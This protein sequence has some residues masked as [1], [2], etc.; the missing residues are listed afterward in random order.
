M[1]YGECL[2]LTS[3]VLWGAIPILVRKGFTALECIGGSGIRLVS[4][5]T[6]ADRRVLVTSALG[7]TSRDSTRRV[8][9]RCVWDHR[10]MLGAIVQL[11]RCGSSWSS[12]RNAPD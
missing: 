7:N 9:V 5:C 3:A 11:P 8:L 6:A 10:A 12:P 1:F 4:Q 2:A